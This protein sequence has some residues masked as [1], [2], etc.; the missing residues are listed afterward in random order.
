MARFPNRKTANSIV[1]CATFAF[2][3]AVVGGLLTGILL[4]ELAVPPEEIKKDPDPPTLAAVIGQNKTAMVALELRLDNGQKQYHWCGTAFALN[5]GDGK[6]TGGATIISCAHVAEKLLGFERWAKANDYSESRKVLVLGDGEI[7]K[8]KRVEVHLDF[9][10]NLNPPEFSA[11]LAK[12]ELES[13]WQAGSFSLP[14]TNL[15]ETDCLQGRRVFTI[16]Y[17][18]ELKTIQYPTPPARFVPTFKAGLIERVTK[19]N[20][21]NF[22]GHVLQHGIQTIGGFS[23]SPLFIETGELVGVVV[24]ASHW[25]Q[26]NTSSGSSQPPATRLIHPAE[27]NFALRADIITSWLR[28]GQHPDSSSKTNTGLR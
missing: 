3:G 4:K 25:R 23:G 17:P 28:P 22:K 21:D 6:P 14:S 12:L 20:G 15:L 10:P 24:A 18:T 19:I 1:A 7:Q 8:I 27:I 9:D 13:K 16:G 2:I 26:S 11:D 5:L